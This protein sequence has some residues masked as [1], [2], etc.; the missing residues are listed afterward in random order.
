MSDIITGVLFFQLMCGAVFCSTSIYQLDLASKHI[1][2]EFFILIFASTVSIATTFPY[3]YYSAHVSLRMQAIGDSTYISFAWYKF[4]ASVQK[5][6]LLIIEN[7]E[8]P[9]IFS[10]YGTINC[11]LETFRKVVFS[12]PTVRLNLK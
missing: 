7:S 2:P 11:S 1:N 3:C 10:G 12:K 8:R 4:P 6:I 5:N 9:K